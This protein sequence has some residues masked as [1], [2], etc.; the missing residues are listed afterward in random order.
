MYWALNDHTIF[1]TTYSSGG[2][3]LSRELFLH[4]TLVNK[5]TIIVKKVHLELEK[6]HEQKSRKDNKHNYKTI[7]P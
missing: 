5:C 7:H 3:D 2:V 6:K 4:L 1:Q